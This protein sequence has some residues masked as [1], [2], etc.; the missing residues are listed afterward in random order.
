MYRYLGINLQS[1]R[2]HG[3]IAVR[4]SQQIWTCSCRTVRGILR[5]LSA[6]GHS[7]RRHIT[8]RLQQ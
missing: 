3:G 4:I 8:Q 5:L 6:D 7:Q 2:M 1:F